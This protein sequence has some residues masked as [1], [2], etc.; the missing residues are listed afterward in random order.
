MPTSLKQVLGGGGAGGGHKVAPTSFVRGIATV[1]NST[2][3]LGD[4]AVYNVDATAGANVI[5]LTGKF[6]IHYLELRK[7]ATSTNN[8]ARIVLTIDGAVIFDRQVT[9]NLGNYEVVLWGEHISDN[10]KANIFCPLICEQSLEVYVENTTAN[11]AEAV[12]RIV[13]L[14]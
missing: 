1:S 5:Q 11:D 13:A 9:T 7:I 6:A 2:A 8:S 12:F 10:M 4:G 3:I 14:P